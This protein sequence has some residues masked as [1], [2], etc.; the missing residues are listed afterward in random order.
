MAHSSPSPPQY[1][2]TTSLILASQQGS[3]DVVKALVD[4]GADVNSRNR[5]GLGRVA[6]DL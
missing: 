5:V 1:Y 4:A 6:Y 3:L 2:G